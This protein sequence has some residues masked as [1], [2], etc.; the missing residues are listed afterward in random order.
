MG[1]TE[2][3]SRITINHFNQTFKK[4]VL[5][6]E[7]HPGPGLDEHFTSLIDRSGW[8]DISRAKVLAGGQLYAPKHDR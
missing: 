3:S 2:R 1:P 4:N 5:T 8:P 6:V 7:A